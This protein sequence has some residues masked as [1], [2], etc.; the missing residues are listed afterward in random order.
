MQTIKGTEIY[1]VLKSTQEY[2]EGIARG[3]QILKKGG[4]VVFPTETVYG[5]GA[6]GLKASAVSKIFKVK[7]RP[8]DNPLILHLYRREQIE[9]IVEEIST[10]AVLLMERYWPGPLTLVL[11]KKPIVPHIVTGGLDT[12]ALRIPSSPIALALIEETGVPLAAPSANFSGS[13]S[14]TS[15]DHVI[16]DLAGRVPLIL[17]GGETGIGLESTVIDMTKEPPLLLRPGG[18]T[19]EDLLS[20]LGEVDIDEG[21]LSRTP[22]EPS[23]VTSPGMKYRHYAPKTPMILVEGPWESTVQIL[24]EKAIEYRARG[25]RVGLFVTEEVSSFFQEKGFSVYVMGSREDLPS[26]GQ[27]L[28]ALLREMDKDHLTLILAQGLTEK[29]LGMAVMNRLR[30]SAGYHIIEA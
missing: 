4:L 17:D 8:P 6:H 9:E 28:F 29:G 11:K 20:I 30:R 26:I 18:I 10:E 25:E 19:L 12:V 24:L 21:V 13:P 22:K 3:S 15:A 2:R 27:H 7:G 14:P 16:S 1:Q 23:S 5:L